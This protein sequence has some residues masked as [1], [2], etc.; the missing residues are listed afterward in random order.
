MKRNSVVAIAVA[1]AAV[2]IGAGS[3]AV[4]RYTEAEDRDSEVRREGVAR[5]GVADEL[6]SGGLLPLERIL[7]LAASHLPGEVL[8]IELEDER[9]RVVYEL[10]ILA[11][12]GRV[13]EIK[14]DAHDGKLI[15]IEE[16]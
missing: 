11:D 9:G 1:V 12:N 15:E 13:R 7:D 5:G 3:Y 16:D 6:R 4:Y 10:K 8:K 2:G 14:L